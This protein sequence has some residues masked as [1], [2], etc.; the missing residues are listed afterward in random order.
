MFGVGHGSVQKGLGQEWNRFWGRSFFSGTRREI[1]VFKEI[2]KKAAR[3]R[4]KE[5][6]SRGRAIRTGDEKV[7]N[8][9][10]GR[11]LAR[12]NPVKRVMV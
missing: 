2:V 8:N 4:A 10:Q 11:E 5:T 12:T 9:G 7:M 3:V 1:N 6:L